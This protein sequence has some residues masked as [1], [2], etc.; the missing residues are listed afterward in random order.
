[1][2]LWEVLKPCAASW[3]NTKA[4]MRATNHLSLIAKEPLPKASYYEST[5]DSF[6]EILQS[7]AE[8]IRR[9]S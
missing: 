4:Y 8:V 7:F 2:A 6:E 9:E 3:R 5:G 1:M